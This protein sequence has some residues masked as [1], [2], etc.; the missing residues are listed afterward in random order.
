M[1]K[2]FDRTIGLFGEENFN[3][4]KDKTIA[5]IGLGGVGGTAFEALVRTG[6]QNFVICD[7]DKVDETN[8]N[9]QILFTSE[10]IDKSKVEI[11][12]KR[13]KSI[14]PKVKVIGIDSKVDAESV[15]KLSQY[16]ID[17]LVDA[18]DEV[19]AKLL[20]CKFVQENN[21]PFL[22]SLGM[23]CRMKVEDVTV[24]KL[25]RTTNDPLAKKIRYQAKEMG[26]DIS[27]INVVF[28]KENKIT[29]GVKLNSTLFTPSAAGLNIASYVISYF[30]Y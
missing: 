9:R 27:K 13:A 16:K 17:F 6:V 26:L 21:I 10:D 4:V 24:T 8:L 2:I 11:A 3:T 19:P 23:A 14:N 12:I 22:M 28:S 25:N 15:K 5:I 20:L 29:E 1:D 18:I 7:F 30:I